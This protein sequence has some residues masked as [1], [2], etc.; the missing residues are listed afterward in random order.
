M[1]QHK[2]LALLGTVKAKGQPFLL[3]WYMILG[4]GVNGYFS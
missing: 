2:T 3:M 4:H 1:F